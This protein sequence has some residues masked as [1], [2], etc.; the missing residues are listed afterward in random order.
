VADALA[1]RR[2]WRSLA[3]AA[4][5][6]VA[7]V[8]ATVV[9]RAGRP[10]PATLPVDRSVRVGVRDGDSI[11]DYLAVSRAELNQLAGTAPDTAVYALV[12]LA[13]YLPPD[14]L[15]P[16]VGPG[17]ASVSA[18]ARVP[19]PRRQTEIVRLPA[20]RL[21]ADVVAAMD[22]VAARKA[23]AAPADP[24]A[25][26]EAAG[27]RQRCACVYALVVRGRPAALRS[28]G[29]HPAVR[30]VDPAPE[31]TDVSS[32]VFVAPLP[33]QADRVQPPPDDGPLPVHR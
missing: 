32:A 28:L 22:L 19:L 15:A 6:L 26:A 25:A 23:E 10:A 1:Q 12:V 18:Y 11:P 4:L 14:R 20:Q 2:R 9:W 5:A 24:V 30:G 31:V 33:E 8:A 17:V 3:V 27:Y 29:A 7:A 21:P 16:L 13:A